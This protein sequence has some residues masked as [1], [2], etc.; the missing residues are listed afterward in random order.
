MCF[1]WLQI[2]DEGNLL[3]SPGHDIYNAKHLSYTVIPKSL[4]Y[5]YH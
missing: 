1:V 5:V 3:E 4:S 2:A